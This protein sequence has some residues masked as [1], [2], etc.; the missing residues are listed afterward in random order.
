MNRFYLRKLPSWEK[1]FLTI[2]LVFCYILDLKVYANADTIKSSTENQPA[3]IVYSSED[4]QLSESQKLLDMLLGHFTTDMTFKSAKEVEEKHL[5]GI[6]TLIYYGEVEDFLP[7]TV[8]NLFDSFQ[9]TKLAIGQNSEQ[10]GNSYAHL[11]YTGMAAVNELTLTKS[12]KKLEIESRLILGVKP[13]S[14]SEIL[15]TGRQ[16]NATHPIF[17]KNNS[18]YYFA[19]DKIDSSF[20]SVLGEVLHDVFQA[21]HQA[22]HPAYLRL[23]D[24]HPLTDSANLRKIAEIL[25]EKKIPYIVSVIPIYRNPETG[26]ESRFSDFPKLLNVLRYMQE[27]GGSIIVHGYTHQYRGDETG[28][29]FE[30]WDVDNNM[31]VTVPPT[32]QPEKKTRADFKSDQ[33]YLDFLAKQKAFETNYIK[34]KVT[35]ATEEIVSYGLYPLAFEAPHYTMSQ[36]GYKILAEHFSTYIGQLQLGD[37]DWRIMTPAPYVTKPTFLHGMT[38]LPETIGFV[39]P[40]HPGAIDDMMK[41]AKQQEIVRDG[42]IAGF[43]HP[44][45]GVSRFVELIERME[46]LPNIH[47][48]DLKKIS[49]SVKV[50]NISVKSAEVDGVT[51]DVDYFGLLKTAP[52]FY[53]PKVKSATNNTMW[54]IAIAAGC[55]VFLFTIY[56]MWLRRQRSRMEGGNYYG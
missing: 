3:L 31:P 36:S 50:A 24:I 13:S 53:T 28:E 37:R 6:K 1:L 12:N 23:E 56:A 33:D 49:T 20:S 22:G 29:G 35:K 38:L 47:W 7:E 41:A 43:Y 34:T 17:I 5:A 48:I 18:T 54:T 26:A 32:E 21:D 14:K 19:S 25:K 15:V 51:T 10:L 46:K 30:F 52:G 2:V 4:G 8:A 16:G 42:Y 55:M 9:G 40:D 27:N 39:E 44:Y 45:L 11:A